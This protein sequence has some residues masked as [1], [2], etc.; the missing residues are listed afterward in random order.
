MTTPLIILNLKKSSKYKKMICSA[1]ELKV[2]QVINWHLLVEV[3]LTKVF[4]I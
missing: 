2:V 1:M 4:C 3:Y